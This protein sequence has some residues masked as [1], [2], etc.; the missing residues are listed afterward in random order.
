[1]IYIKPLLIFL[2]INII[3]IIY[4]KKLS[5]V[6]NIYDNHNKRK[7]HKKK[8]PLLGGLI[9]IIN[10]I[11]FFFL[12]IFNFFEQYPQNEVFISSKLNFL[13]L[14]SLIIFLV[15]LFDDKYDLNPNLKLFILTIIISIFLYFDNS[16]LLKNINFS[17]L[18]KNYNVGNYS[19][20]LTVLCYLL[21]INACNMFDGINIQSGSYFLTFIIT[22]SIMDNFTIFNLVIIFSLIIFLMLNYNGK[23]FMGDGGIYLLSFLLGYISIKT[24]NLKI[25]NDVD[26]I[27]LIMMIPGFDMLRMFVTRIIKKKNPFRPDKNHLHHLLLLKLN[28]SKTILILNVLIL[29][30]IIFYFLGLNNLINILILVFIYSFFI[31]ILKTII[32]E[33]DDT[34][35]F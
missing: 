12:E 28:Y 15:G 30:P 19:Y 34:K 7:I 33:K 18:D 31:I 2:V 26:T 32:S 6:L 35:S 14:F 16:L 25:I 20:I 11:V 5:L 13:V 23:I 22:L 10:L 21:F 3:T 4:L 17:F 24:Y 8:T 1:M 27:F 29:L 9:I